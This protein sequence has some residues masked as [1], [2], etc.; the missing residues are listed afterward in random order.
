MSVAMARYLLRRR[1]AVPPPPSDSS[2]RETGAARP[3]SASFRDLM[4]P[5]I[6]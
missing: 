5:G 2:H 3:G 4:R 6:I 1:F